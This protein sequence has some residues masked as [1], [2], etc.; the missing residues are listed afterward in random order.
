MRE[1][2]EP[3]ALCLPDGRLNPGA[4]GWSRRPLHDTALK[5]WGRTKRW[6]YWCV[7][8]EGALVALTVSDLDFIGVNGIYFAADGLPPVTSE[9]IAPF[10]LGTRLPASLGGRAASRLPRIEIVDGADEIAL[11]SQGKIEVDLTVRRPAGHETLNVVVPWSE[12]RFQFTSKQTALPATGTVRTGGREYVFGADSWAVLDHGRGR[13][14]R[15]MVWNWGAASGRTGGHVVGLQFGGKWTAG[16]GMTEN[17]LC[18]DG[19]IT[20][21]PR[22]LTWSYDAAD[23]HAPWTITGP[24]VDVVFTP[25]HRRAVDVNALLLRNRTVQQ[26]GRYSG[27]IEPSPGERVTVDGLRGWAE[28]VT[29]RW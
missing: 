15:D 18:V 12:R 2:T 29:M 7:M 20:A 14:P 16:T 13:W 1:I 21:I 11:R 5:G 3:V 25:F 24:G 23:E 17:A 9:A 27:V 19:R 4:V 10:G 8:T 22:E 28:E 26:F 6:E